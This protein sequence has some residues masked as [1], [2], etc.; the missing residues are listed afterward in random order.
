VI[1]KGFAASFMILLA[2][3][4]TFTEDYRAFRETHNS[5]QPL[6][7]FSEVF[8]QSLAD[9]LILLKGKNIAGHTLV[10]NQPV[11]D[12]CERYVLDVRYSRV[13]PNPGAFHVYVFCNSNLPSSRQIMPKQ[14]FDD[15]EGFLMALSTT[16][17]SWAKSM[18]FRVESPPKFVG[19][20]YDHYE[21]TIN[22]HGRVSSV[23]P[24]DS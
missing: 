5:I 18:R 4:C 11:S 20:V 12:A 8:S 1:L 3:G 15:K 21:F 9:Y 7:A 23:S 10:E 16:Y 6:M 13:T 24:I 17:R 22:Q 14:S 2:S 19:G